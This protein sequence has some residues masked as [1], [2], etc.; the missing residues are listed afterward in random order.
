M[1]AQAQPAANK[2][3]PWF[4][5]L[6][7]LLASLAGLLCLRVLGGEL[8]TPHDLRAWLG[9]LGGWAPVAFVAFLALRPVSLLPGQF[10]TAVGGILFGALWG[11]VYALVGSVLASLVIFFLAR[12]LGSRLVRRAAGTHYEA[13]RRAARHHDFKFSLLV[14]LNPFLP[15]DVAQAA[16]AAS[17]ARLWPVALG[18]LL[19]TVPGT[20]LTA[21]FGSALGQGKT[22]LTLVS[23]V[24]LLVSLLLGAL[25]GHRVF[26]EVSQAPVSGLAGG[27]SHPSA[28]GCERVT[29]SSPRPASS[30]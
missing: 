21:Q 26:R 28:S 15:T 25:L 12:R 7:P 30:A 14:C 4:K 8:L 9:P 13:L 23:A 20:F 29:E 11:T 10:F 2:S 24:G 17:G 6:A 3:V 1:E 27:E 22:I 16:A 19:G 18:T 5:V